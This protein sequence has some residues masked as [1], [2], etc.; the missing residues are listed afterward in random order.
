[1]NYQEFETPENPLPLWIEE[2]ENDRRNTHDNMVSLNR[3]MTDCEHTVRDCKEIMGDSISRDF[4]LETQIKITNIVLAFVMCFVAAIFIFVIADKVNAQTTAGASKAMT[5]SMVTAV[6]NVAAEP[7]LVIADDVAYIYKGNKVIAF[8]DH[9]S[10]ICGCTE[11]EAADEPFEG[12]RLVVDVILNR[13]DN[14]NYPNTIEGVITQPYRFTS[15]WNGAIEWRQEIGISEDTIK[16]VN[17]ELLERGYPG[18]LHFQE[19]SYSPYGTAWRKV[20]NH[21]FSI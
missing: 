8:Y 18:V 3:R 17:M 11:A 12:K 5:E 1:M 21:Y 13:Y 14:P 19:G 16:A 10:L 15:Y 9:Y 6:E 4:K 2:V 7:E 20:G